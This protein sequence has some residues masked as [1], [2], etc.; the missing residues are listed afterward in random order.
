MLV[1]PRVHDC[2]EV[3][4]YHDEQ[5]NTQSER[6][7]LQHGQQETDDSQSD[8]VQDKLVFGNYDALLEVVREDLVAQEE[9]FA[10]V[11]MRL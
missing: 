7:I 4:Y 8:H 5:P 11:L 10:V 9:L 2:R 1:W 3:D 6:G